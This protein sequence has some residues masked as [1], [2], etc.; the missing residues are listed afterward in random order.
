MASLELQNITKTFGKKVALKDVNFHCKE[1]EMFCLLGASGAGKSTSINVISGVL[2]PDS[3][4]V[5]IGNVDQS[6]V[7]PQDRNI[8]TAFENYA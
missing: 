3:G 1:G 5:L 7:F 8:A 2:G 6:D 4:K